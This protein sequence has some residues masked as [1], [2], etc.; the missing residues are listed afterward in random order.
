M[1]E[2]RFRLRAEGATYTNEIPILKLSAVRYEQLVLLVEGRVAEVNG[3]PFISI[4]EL[5]ERKIRQIFDV[6]IDKYPPAS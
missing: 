2:H 3:N 6:F 4:N 5:P 1:S